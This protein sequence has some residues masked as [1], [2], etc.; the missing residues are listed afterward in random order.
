MKNK[1]FYLLLSGLCLLS[2]SSCDPW[3][4]DNNNDGGGDN[5]P[6]A[7]N[8]LKEIHTVSNGVEGKATYT[9]DSENR[10]KTV[11]SYDD[12]SNNQSYSLTTNNY[13]GNTIETIT[14]TYID[15]A[16]YSTATG[17]STTN[18]NTINVEMETVSN[19]EV[20]LTLESEILFELPCGVQQNSITTE[21]FG[22][23]ITFV[24]TY[25]YTDANCSYKEYTEGQ[26]TQTVTNDDKNNPQTTPESIA[27]GV[28]MHNPILVVTPDGTTETITYTYNEDDY[29]TE[30][31]HTYN[32]GSGQQ[33]YTQTFT[34]Y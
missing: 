32:Q 29:P 12:I 15:G 10:V 16:L 7:G 2:L 27:M 20:M 19:G 31:I 34:Y 11:T 17:T 13:N 3:E 22:S 14:E 23:P 6:T 8:L 5:P 1:V 18:G 9:Y 24:M 4:D 26:L 33:D 21:L 28:V 25:D 30:A